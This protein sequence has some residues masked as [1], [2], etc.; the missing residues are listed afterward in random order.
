MATRTNAGYLEE[1][2]D[3]RLKLNDFV[4]F[5]NAGKATYF[6]DI[7]LKLR[8]LY[9]DKSGT[10]ALL[11]EV[12]DRHSIKVKVRV[13]DTVLE[14]IEKGLLPSS[15]ADGLVVNI[16]NTSIS[17]FK[18]SGQGAIV[19]PFTALERKDILIHEHTYSYKEVIEV[20][21]DRMAAH[22]D[23]TI[24]DGHLRLHEML[25][26][27]GSLPIAQQAIIDIARTSIELIDNLQEHILKG[28]DFLHISST[29]NS[30]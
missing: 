27:L 7:A 3:L 2:W 28:V 29:Q 21:S 8:V 15:L 4:D 18:L 30:G 22:V 11:K 9:F 26:P 10:K 6:K 25:L 17:W 24:S 16:S 1:L 14:A 20:V 5:V 13:H 12:L 23:E 19:S